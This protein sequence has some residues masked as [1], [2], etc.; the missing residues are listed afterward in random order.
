LFVFLFIYQTTIFIH[1]HGK[2]KVFNSSVAA[3]WRTYVI[4]DKILDYER[5]K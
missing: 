4:L 2:I 3:F 1:F 5:L